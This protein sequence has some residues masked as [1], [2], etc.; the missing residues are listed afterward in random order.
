MRAQH[1]AL[2]G[3]AQ[4]HLDGSHTIDRVGSDP[5]ERNARCKS[6]LDHL[7]GDLGFGDEADAVGNMAG[8]ITQGLARTGIR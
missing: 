6:P 5:F 7:C 8:V 2:A 1:I 4:L 3:P